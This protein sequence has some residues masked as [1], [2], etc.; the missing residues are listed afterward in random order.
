VKTPPQSPDLNPIE[1][2][3]AYL[4]KRVGIRS[5][6]TKDDLKKF[7]LEEWA[8]LPTEYVKNLILSMP[9]R[10]KA[11]IEANGGHTKY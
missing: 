1:H 2:W 4:K 7:I 5:P 3:W 11:V 10:L 8:K 9:R 6:K